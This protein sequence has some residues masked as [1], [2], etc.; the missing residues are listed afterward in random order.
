MTAALQRDQELL[1]MNE[2]SAR[3]DQEISQAKT[4]WK[5]ASQKAG[6][7]REVRRG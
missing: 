7:R 3:Y 6:E 4:E 5:R 1:E 2:E